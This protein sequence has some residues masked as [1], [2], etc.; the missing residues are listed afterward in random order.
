MIKLKI[1]LKQKTS[2]IQVECVSKRVEGKCLSK[3]VV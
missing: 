3:F 1:V 2:K